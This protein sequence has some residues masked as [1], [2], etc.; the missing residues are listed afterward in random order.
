[1]THPGQTPDATGAQHRLTAALDRLTAV[2]RGMTAHPDEDNC[3]CHWGG[4]EELALLK[5]P[6]VELDP[7]LLKR[8]WQA[9]DWTYKAAML[10]RILPQFATALTDG[11]IKPLFGLEE[12]GLVFHR[13]GWQQWPAEQAAA[14]RE[15]LDAWW[16]R[17]LTDP[18][19]SVPSYQVLA[20]TA[21]ASG[22]LA[23]WLRAWEAHTHPTADRHL[24][25]AVDQ[26]ESELLRDELPW[27]TWHDKE[28]TRAELAAWLLRH[29]PARL[30]S[31]GAPD[32]L[33]HRIRLLG[34]T[35]SDRWDD[36]HWPGF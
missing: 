15:F 16:E 36:P 34:L 20:L 5:V 13:A 22:T 24:A 35:E 18:D 6:D 4:A 12:A 25:Q 29:A 7:D 28:A 31:H 23:P 33:L 9:V 3:T 17:T 2:F 8:T 10:R 14:V 21:E 1:M 26:W 19:P 27:D 11:R 32:D 30:R